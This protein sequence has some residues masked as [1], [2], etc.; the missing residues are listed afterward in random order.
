MKRLFSSVILAAS[1]FLQAYSQN[2]F[3]N[4]YVVMNN[5]DTISGLINYGSNHENTLKCLFKTDQQATIR[6][7]YPDSIIAYRFDNSKYFISKKISTTDS[8]KIFLEFI[9]DGIVD[10]YDYFDESGVHYLISKT[11]DKFIELKNDIRTTTVN[12]V[13][14]ERDSKEYIGTL[15]TLFIDSPATLKKADNVSLNLNSLIDLSEGYH[16]DV[17]PSEECITYAK[18]KVDIRFSFGIIAGISYSG[19]SITETQRTTGRFILP[20][21]GTG[22]MLGTLINISEPFFSR[23]LS[24]QSEITVAYNKYS[25]DKS[26]LD[27]MTLNIPLQLKY[28]FPLKNIQLSALAGLGYNNILVFDYVSTDYGKYD[29]IAGRNQLCAIGGIEFSYNL[30][31]KNRILLQLRYEYN[32]GTEHKGHWS[33]IYYYGGENDYNEFD[34]TTPKLTFLVGYQF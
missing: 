4:G 29:F 24:I 32:S 3:Q 1:I 7:F 19:I 33:D 6:T 17:C 14:Y 11:D 23:R 9:F 22:I 10:L 18:K 12:G 34:M 16:K 31:S 13:K 26:S 15:K 21:Y 20:D 30:I 28:S 25:T 8:T 2:D 5:N 27:M